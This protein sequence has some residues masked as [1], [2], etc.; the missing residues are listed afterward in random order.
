MIR[1]DSSVFKKKKMFGFD[2][3]LL[4]I[5]VGVLGI[6]LKVI[7]KYSFTFPGNVSENLC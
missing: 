2:Y 5:F 7:L 3:F 4:F 6:F 1:C